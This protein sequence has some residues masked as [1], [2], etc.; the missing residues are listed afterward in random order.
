MSSNNIVHAQ[1]RFRTVDE[2]L[3]SI[4]HGGGGGDN[5]G[6]EARVQILEQNMTEVRER[7]A[8]IET[9]LDQTATKN[10]VSEVKSELY[11]AINAQ[12]WR[13]IGASATLV[14]AVFF[15]ARYLPPAS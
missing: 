15:I 14:A 4:A 1:D 7:L 13:V 2:R 11:K 12:T 9:R 8:R 3:A 10:D 6:M 5:T